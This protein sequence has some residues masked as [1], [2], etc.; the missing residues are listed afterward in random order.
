[1]HKIFTTHQEFLSKKGQH[2]NDPTVLGK[3]F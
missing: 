1:M 2:E 3:D